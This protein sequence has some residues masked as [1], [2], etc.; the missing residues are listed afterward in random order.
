NDMEGI[1][2]DDYSAGPCVS[3][4]SLTSSFFVFVREEGHTYDHMASREY[5]LPNDDSW[6]YAEEVFH[7][8][9]HGILGGKPLLGSVEN[10]EGRVLDVGTGIGWWA[11]DMADG[12][13]RADV[14]GIDLSPIQPVYVPVNCRFIIDDFTTSY[15][16]V[17]A[18]SD[19]Y[20]NVIH[21]RNMA[22]AIYDWTRFIPWIKRELEPG[23]LAEFQELLWCPCIQD[24]GI[25]KPYTGPLAEFFQ[26]LAQAFGAV[27]ISLDAPRYLR[28]GLELSDFQDVSQQDFLIPLGKWS[29]DPKLKDMGALFYFFLLVAIEPLS[30]RVLRR[31]LNYSPSEAKQWAERFKKTLK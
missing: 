12:N 3:T 22:M 26:T 14:I 2:G 6:T 30:S 16:L 9:L 4:A 21:C 20:P 17:F 18:C 1:I 31:G 7:F 15:N 10:F 11:I 19:Y 27:G 24:D 28:T 13:P 29:N 25:I 8:V 23:G 5:M